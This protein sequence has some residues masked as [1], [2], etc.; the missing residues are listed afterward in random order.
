VDNVRGRIWGRV[1]LLCIAAVLLLGLA[2]VYYHARGQA[3]VAVMATS[4]QSAEVI[5]IIDP[6]HGGVDGG[7]VSPA[8]IYERELNLAIGLKLEALA[9]LYGIPVEM[10]RRTA[11]LDYP[12]DADSIR[13]KKVVDTRARVA[14]INAAPNAVVI[15]IHQN[16]FA[17][18][19][20]S[21]PQVLFADTDASKEFAQTAQGILIAAL[22][23]KKERCPLPVPRSVYLMKHIDCPAILVECGFLSNPWEVLLLEADSYQ[24]KLAASLFAGFMQSQDL[25]IARYFG[26]SDPT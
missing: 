12:E 8:G 18:T 23:P 24:R 19:G 2:G 9:A 3:H 17:D 14:Q 1:I 6:G 25:F 11:D 13:A 7:A 15:S 5:L 20:V 22:Q 26:G 21:G 16:M 4:D 10:T